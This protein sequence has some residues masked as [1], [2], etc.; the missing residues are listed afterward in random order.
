M[1]ERVREL[2]A[3]EKFDAVH[4]EGIEMMPYGLL[5]RRL[6]DPKLTYDAHNAEYLLQRRAFTTDLKEARSWPRAGYSL[7]Q[8]WRLRGFERGACNI[9]DH[10][11]AVSEND[12]QALARLAPGAAARMSVLPN[13][14]DTEYWLPTADYAH[15][16]PLA[17]DALVFDGTMDFRPNVDAAVWFAGEIWPLIRSERPH[18]HFYI[19]GRNPSPQVLALA[20]R[21]GITVTGVVDDPRPWVAGASAYVVP[22]RMGGGTRLKVLQAMAM[23]RAIVS[24]PVGAEGIEL[25]NGRHM[26][27]ANS[28]G[29]IARATLDLLSDPSR[30]ETLGRAARELV[31]ERYAWRVLLPRLD[32]IYPV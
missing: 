14:V 4:V 15:Q 10:V 32:S 28:P 6:Q 20:N 3:H 22:L 1:R 17:G 2:C 18:A 21:P 29:E 31:A 25:E 9:S 8:W 23:E 5:A 30:R 12:K 11:L 13:G 27:L 16:D 19:V 24:T 7:V 26:V